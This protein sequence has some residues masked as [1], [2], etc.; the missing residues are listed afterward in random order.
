MPSSAIISANKEV[1]SAYSVK[2]GS[3][4]AQSTTVT[5]KRGRYHSYTEEEKARIAKRAAEFGVASTIRHFSKEFVDRQLKESTV[6]ELVAKYKKEV[7]QRF[8]LGMPIEIK[9]LPEKKRGH[10]CLLGRELDNQ[11][12]EYVKGLREGK[13]VINIIISVIVIS[14]ALGIV[15]SHNSD[16]LEA[17]G[18]HIQLSKEWAKSFLGRMGFVKR[19][20]IMKASVS[21]LDFAALKDQFLFDIQTWKK[22]QRS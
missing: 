18:G 3:S 1:E 22:Y 11:L 4:S 7:A 16:L 13:S 9:K 21:S 10:P 20:A 15:K 14:T 5:Q 19:K 17:N 2:D 8:K 6:R 12:Q